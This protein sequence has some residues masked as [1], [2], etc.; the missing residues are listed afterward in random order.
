MAWAKNGTGET[1]SGNADT[2]TVTGQISKIFNQILSQSFGSGGTVQWKTRLGKTTIDTNNNYT[3]RY[4]TNGV[5]ELT[6]IEQAQIYMLNSGAGVAAFM[7]IGYAINISAEE[8]L[9][10]MFC[11]WAGTAGASN[12][13]ER[14]EIYA[15]WVNT[16]NQFDTLQLVNISTGDFTSG[17]SI[18]ALG[19]N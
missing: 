1:L 7:H 3:T 2:V 17:S 8:K 6:E 11:G 19:T 5:T 12:A 13:P 16:S 18:S 15:K 14:A 10:I 4:C 9:L